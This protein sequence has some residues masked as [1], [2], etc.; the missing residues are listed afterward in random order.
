WTAVSGASGY[1]IY[2]A[3][4]SAGTYT[5]V[6]TIA[7][8]TAP[9]YTNTS[10]A[11]GTTYYY[12]VNAYRLVGT[13][14]VYGSQ[15]AAVSAKPIPATV[16]TITAAR[17]SATSIKISWPAVSGASGYELFRSTSS[18]GTYTLIRT[19]T[20][21]YY[22]NTGLKTGTTYYYKV[23]AY[24]LVGTTKVYGG[25]SGIKYAKP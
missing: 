18:A 22:T 19:Q 7:A 14:K 23:R 16:G 6:T 2:R 10:L 4:S 24:R 11:T 3:T 1:S 8:A 25:Y 13:T 21:L 15:A 5:L 17:Y 12:K 20:A 9:T